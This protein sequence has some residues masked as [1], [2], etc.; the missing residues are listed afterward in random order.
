MWDDLQKIQ[1]EQN[2]K[3]SESYMKSIN[4][5]IRTQLENSRSSLDSIRQELEKNRAKFDSTFSK[6]LSE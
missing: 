4:D 6:D 5:S 3:I 1:R 2:E